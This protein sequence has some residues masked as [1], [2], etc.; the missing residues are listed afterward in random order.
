MPMG[1]FVVAEKCLEG[2]KAGSV[3]RLRLFLEGH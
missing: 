3:F 2:E 1:I